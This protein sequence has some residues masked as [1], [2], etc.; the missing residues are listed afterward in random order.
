MNSQKQV[1]K[2]KL[3]SG[4]DHDFSIQNESLDGKQRQCRYD[5]W[6]ITAQ[7]LAGLRLQEDF[8]A[9]AK[10]KATEAIPLGLVQPALPFGISGTDFAS[11]GG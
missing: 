3:A 5:F 10:S 2:R 6:E 11:A 9:F 1:V 7:G 4:K 8:C